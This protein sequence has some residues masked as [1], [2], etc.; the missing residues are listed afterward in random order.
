VLR[1]SSR[2]S[3][4]VSPR[5]W[6]TT[7]IEPVHDRLDHAGAGAYV[8]VTG[9]G[10]IH[11]DPYGGEHRRDRWCSPLGHR[12]MAGRWRRG[13]LHQKAYFPTD[14]S[15]RRDKRIMEKSNHCN[16]QKEAE[17]NVDQPVPAPFPQHYEQEHVTYPST[18]HQSYAH[19]W[20]FKRPF[21]KTLTTL[22]NAWHLRRS[23]KVAP[24]NLDFWRPP[25][26][27]R[28][29]SSQA[30][31]NAF[32]SFFTAGLIVTAILQWDTLKNTLEENR[33]LVITTQKQVEVAENTNK[34]A[35]ESLQ[36]TQRAYVG[37]HSL[38]TNLQHR[39]I[40]IMLEN[41]GKVPAQD[42]TVHAHEMRTMGEKIV[43][44][45][46]GS[47]KFGGTSQIA[48]SSRHA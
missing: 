10:A 27:S 18:A 47:P 3:G 42:I 1:V 40:E 20:R 29:P 8:D 24:D 2:A 22:F 16:E 13:A 46:P 6:A 25:K 32:L 37:V 34:M 43:G 39:Y 9:A 45:T 11:H 12:A 41:I 26:P 31:Y 28:R 30:V 15:A 33:K 5:V 48:L 7:V 17:D 4:L 19:I 44:H 36:I 35:K 14:F 23:T 21:G 38:G